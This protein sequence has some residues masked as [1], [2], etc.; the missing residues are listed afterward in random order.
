MSI[1]HKDKEKLKILCWIFFILIL[2][3]KHIKRIQKRA[4]RVH[5]MCFKEAARLPFYNSYLRSIY[6]N[7]G[8]VFSF[9]SILFSKTFS[10]KVLFVTSKNKK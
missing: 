2:F 9:K 8:E 6:A 3:Y 7:K 1:K 5:D 4:S 10:K